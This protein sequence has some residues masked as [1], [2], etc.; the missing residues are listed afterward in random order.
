MSASR[1]EDTLLQRLLDGDL[2]GR[3]QDEVAALV[4]ASAHDRGRQL[5]LERLS[6]FIVSVASEDAAQL[7]EAES[8]GLFEAISAGVRGQ[9]SDQKTGDAATDADATDGDTQRQRPRLRLIEGEGLGTL[10]PRSE[11]VAFEPQL[12]STAT[13]SQSQ[14]PQDPQDPQDK[15]SARWPGFVAVV[16]LAAAA[17]LA[18]GLR[19]DESQNPRAGRDSSATVTPAVTTRPAPEVVDS[20]HEVIVATHHGTEVEEVDFGSN[21]GTVFQV[22]GEQDVPL[23]VVWVSDEEYVR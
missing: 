20:D 23:A 16:A 11:K 4:E 3:E 22:P 1:I 2:A 9:A 12:G 21:S 17:L 5:A 7:S 15:P 19:P 10:P 13:P 6:G 18:I 8:R 14:N